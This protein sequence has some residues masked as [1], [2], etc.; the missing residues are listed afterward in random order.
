MHVCED[1]VDTNPSVPTAVQPE[2][3]NFGHYLAFHASTQNGWVSSDRQPL[4]LVQITI[5]FCG[6]SD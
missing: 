6:L 1:Y 2:C 4:K 3:C 5:A